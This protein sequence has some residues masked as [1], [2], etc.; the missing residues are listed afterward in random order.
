MNTMKEFT[1]SFAVSTLLNSSKLDRYS[2]VPVSQQYFDLF[3]FVSIRLRDG[4]HLN[5][6][7]SLM[8]SVAAQP[9]IC[10]TV[11]YK[12]L[13]RMSILNVHAKVMD[14][15]YKVQASICIFTEVGESYATYFIKRVP[16]GSCFYLFLFY[17][18]IILLHYSSI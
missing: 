12:T 1:Q 15:V 6:K 5:R 13:S 8:P 18:S 17:I 14:L 9:S 4:F 10:I 11:Q 7:V 2:L 16:I 3:Q